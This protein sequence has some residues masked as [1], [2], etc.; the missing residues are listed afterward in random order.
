[1]SWPAP[2]CGLAASA[3]Q[4]EGTLAPGGLPHCPPSSEV[5][6]PSG[7]PPAVVRSTMPVLPPSD[8]DF[9]SP[10]LRAPQGGV[11][12]RVRSAPPLHGALPNALAHPLLA[13]TPPQ[14]V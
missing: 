3:S 7:V 9:L 8:W 14:Q 2:G 10:V 4:A 6:L 11:R 12:G 13:A 5:A 1:M